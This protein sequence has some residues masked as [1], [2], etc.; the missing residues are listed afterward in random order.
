MKIS[1]KTTSSLV[2]IFAGEETA[3][4]HAEKQGSCFLGERYN[5]Q[6]LIR[7]TEDIYGAEMV[8][9]GVNG[10]C[11]LYSVQEIKAGREYG[12]GLADDYVLHSPNGYYPDLLV[13]KDTV[14]V[15]KGENTV[16]W[17]SLS[18]LK[19]G[20]N[21]IVF[22]LVK[23]GCALASCVYKLT[24]IG[25]SLPETDI[26]LTNWMHYDCIAEKTGTEPFSTEFYACFENYLSAYVESG[27]NTLLI[28]TFTPALD[29][30]VGGE[31]RTTQ[32]V[33]V[34]LDNG[35]YRFDF[36]KL[37]Q[38]LDFVTARGIRY[39]E[40]AHLYTQWGAEFCPKV[41]AVVDGEEKKIFG[42]ETGSESG[43]Y[44]AFLNAY[45]PA[46]KTLLE[47]RG[48]A[49][50]CFIHLSDEPHE[51][52]VERYKRLYEFVKPLIGEMKTFDALSEFSFYQKNA[53]DIP[54]VLTSRTRP[55]EVEKIEHFAYYC[56]D[57][58]TNY[59]SNRFFAMPSERTRVIGVQLYRNGAKGFLH[60]G[61][62]FYN[63][64]FSVRVI[65]PYEETDAGGRFPS[66]DSY[67]VYPYGRGVQK[68]IRYFLM[69][70][71]FDDYRACKLAERI[72]G[73]EKTMELLKK[74]GVYGYNCYPKTAA[75]FKRMREEL[76]WLVA[77]RLKK[78]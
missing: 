6:I 12:Y 15:K 26:P 36:S 1:L 53:V 27:L 75:G 21:T 2:K 73:K 34:F 29:T 28:P 25:V 13:E 23:D 3:F 71:A 69:N 38:F 76:N 31:R 17:V 50:N 37:E 57:P 56:C 55:F 41:M 47:G 62:N 45:L 61:Y 20:E 33:Q 43:E 46:L 18:E 54:A 9:Q 19:A 39:Y 49:K 67:I 60:W 24:V 8:V 5:L 35:K 44:K 68:S 59:E 77:R 64:Q 63:A 4:I 30:A 16:L 51:E 14:D 52:H 7:S 32:L 78:K 72:V 42:W 48:I 74:F 70:E 66:G 10:K 11:A 22:S 58:C 65:N 40:L